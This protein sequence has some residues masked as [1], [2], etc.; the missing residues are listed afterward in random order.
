MSAR[1]PFKRL[2]RNR[3]GAGVRTRGRVKTGTPALT[4]LRQMLLNIL[5]VLTASRVGSRSVYAG[6]VGMWRPITM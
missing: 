1:K 5:D 6:K 4:L 2:V 3:V